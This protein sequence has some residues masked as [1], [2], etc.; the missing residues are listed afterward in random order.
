MPKQH[1]QQQQQQI[2]RPSSL[3]LLL[4]LFLLPNAAQAFAPARVPTVPV[5]SFFASATATSSIFRRSPLPPTAP[6]SART[7]LPRLWQIRLPDQQHTEDYFRFIEGKEVRTCDMWGYRVWKARRDTA[8]WGGG[9]KRREGRSKWYFKDGR[10]EEERLA[11]DHVGH[12]APIIRRGSS[13]LAPPTGLCGQKFGCRWQGD[14][15]S[16]R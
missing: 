11:A 7:P 15:L 4:L 9:R 12:G 5:T 13:E 6:S 10:V 3:Q 1:Q 2:G 8:I 16:I 14:G